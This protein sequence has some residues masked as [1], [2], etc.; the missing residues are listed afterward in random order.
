[1]LFLQ[2]YHTDLPIG[3]ML[4]EIQANY[5]KDQ[6]HPQSPVLFKCVKKE[7]AEEGGPAGVGKGADELNAKL[8]AVTGVEESLLP[9]EDA[10]RNYSPYTAEPMDLADVERIIYLKSTYQFMSLN[11]YRAPNHTD[12]SCGPQSNILA[13]SSDADHPGEYAIA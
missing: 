3:P 1:M 5:L 11:I 13:R 10:N 2:I 4:N 9:I 7:E 6:V 8:L 12:H